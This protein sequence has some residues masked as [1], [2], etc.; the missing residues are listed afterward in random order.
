MDGERREVDVGVPVV[1]WSRGGGNDCAG[2]PQRRGTRRRLVHRFAV[3]I[4][5][6]VSLVG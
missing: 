2:S 5:V 6:V 3:V 4:V 1:L